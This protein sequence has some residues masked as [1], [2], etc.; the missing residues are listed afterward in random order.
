MGNSRWG[1]TYMF[2]T[3]RFKGKVPSTCRLDSTLFV[4][5]AP[6][7]LHSGHFTCVDPKSD[8]PLP[9]VDLRATCLVRA[10]CVAGWRAE[11]PLVLAVG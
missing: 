10:I 11:V 3:G 8:S 6:S 7:Y 1:T 9:P 5:G 4:L 2:S